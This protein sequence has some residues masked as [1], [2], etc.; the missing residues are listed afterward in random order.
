MHMY[1]QEGKRWR[2]FYSVTVCGIHRGFQFRR[3]RF[4]SKEGIIFGR[5][6]RKIGEILAWET[7]SKG[8]K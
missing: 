4:L 6:R 5:H 1:F 8:E 7:D 2:K 3:A